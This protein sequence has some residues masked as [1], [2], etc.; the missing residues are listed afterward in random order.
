MNRIIAKSLLAAA[1]LISFVS[2]DINKKDD[3]WKDVYNASVTFRIQ[4]DGSYYLK[5]DDTTALVVLNSSLST[6]PFKDK[7]EKRA[8]VQYKLYENPENKPAN[9][10]AEEYKYTKYVELYSIDTIQTKNPMLYDPDADYG[11]SSIGLYV[12]ESIFP[13]TMIE[14]G[15]LNLCFNIPVWYNSKHEINVVY[16]TNPD[17]PY[18]LVVKHKNVNNVIDGQPQAFIMNFPLKSLPDTGGKTVK[19]TL[20]WYSSTQRE[21]VEKQFD[22]CSRTDW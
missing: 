1:A 5:Q 20:K 16:G 2:C 21:M 6:Y 22:Y 14:D 15:Y 18:E 8:L 19:L 10:A 3:M 17:D 9:P 11:D 12:S 7:K 13:T 4:E